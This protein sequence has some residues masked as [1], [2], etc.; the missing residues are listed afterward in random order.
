VDPSRAAERLLTATLVLAAASSILLRALDPWG[1]GHDVALYLH[2]GEL[3]LDGNVP[4]VDFVDLNPPLVMYLSTLPAALGR[5]F[6]VSPILVT[7][8]LVIVAT[9]ASIASAMTFARRAGAPLSSVLAL[10]NGAVLADQLVVL[11]GDSAQREHWFALAALPWLCRRSMRW[12]GNAAGNTIG[13]ALVTG[14]VASLKPQFLACLV[15]AELVGWTVARRRP[16][17]DG[18]LAVLAALPLLYAAHFALLPHAMREAFF[19]R[20]IPLVVD[21]Y[22]LWDGAPGVAIWICGAVGAGIATLGVVQRAPGVAAMGAFVLAST[23]TIWQQHKFWLYHFVPA[24]LVGISAS[25]FVLPGL[26]RGATA[27]AS[28][29]WGVLLLVLASLYATATGSGDDLTDALASRVVPGD[30]LLVVSAE[31]GNT[32]PAL[33]RLGLEPGSRWLWGFPMPI[34]RAQRRGDEPT[35]AEQAFVRELADDADTRRPRWLLLLRTVESPHPRPAIELDARAWL[36]S[37]DAG[38]S[39]LAAYAP[40]GEVVHSIG[41]TKQHLEILERR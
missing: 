11:A 27:V 9:A 10:G 1:L 8:A 32:Y 6:H 26:L 18:E 25:A 31:V 36:E 14:V 28:A 13:L 30:G 5:L 29:G 12:T 34:L 41:A 3:L 39:L 16:T 22:A 20:V 35:P 24:E 33:L 37:M 38:R 40:V 17:L 19:G 21:G 4:Y 2:C 23:A 15:V 7:Q